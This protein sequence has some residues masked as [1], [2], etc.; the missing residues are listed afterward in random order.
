VACVI[1]KKVEPPC[2]YGSLL[3]KKTIDHED[4]TPQDG[5]TFTLKKDGQIIA[6]GTTGSNG[7][8]LF[9]GLI[10]GDY[11][12]EEGKVAGYVNVKGLGTYTVDAGTDPTEA[13]VINTKETPD[14][15]SLRVH[16]TINTENGDPQAGVKFK[17]RTEDGELVAQGTTGDDGEYFF[18]GLEPGRYILTEGDVDGYVN[19]SGLGSY[20]VEPNEIEDAYV[21]NKRKPHQIPDEPSEPSEPDTPEPEPQPEPTPTPPVVEEPPLIPPAVTPP[22]PEPPEPPETVPDLPHTGGN[23]L[24][25][26]GNGILL[27]GLGLGVRRFKR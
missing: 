17:L 19:V 13:H 7:E 16:K 20:N 10:P 6:Q 15:G 5:V 25:Y 22:A 2:E 23:T 26:L 1:N 21:V 8:Y 18:S 9:S 14:T 4:G 27:L 11:T 3:V 24:A 12:L